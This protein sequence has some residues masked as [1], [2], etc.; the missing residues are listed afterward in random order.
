MVGWI[1]ATLAYEGLL[2]AGPDFDRDKVIAATNAMTDFDAGGLIE[3]VDWSAPTPLHA[4]R[5]AART[6]GRSATSLV[7]GGGRRVRDR[8]HPDEP[9]AV[10]EPGRPR[11]VG[12]R[13][14]GVRL[15][16]DADRP[17]R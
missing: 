14:D 2:A 8:G 3:P 5:P 6:P 15:I 13:T 17:T 10:L 12:A 9:V 1:N 16:G 4:G 7:R 11:L